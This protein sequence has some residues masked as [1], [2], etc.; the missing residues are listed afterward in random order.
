MSLAES[1]KLAWSLPAL[2]ALDDETIGKAWRALGGHPQALIRLSEALGT[3]SSL[4]EAIRGVIA[5]CW[6]ESGAADRFW[7]IATDRATYAVLL[8]A[9]VYRV[10]FAPEALKFQLVARGE[11]GGD[12]QFLIEGAPRVVRSGL[13]CQHMDGELEAY[14]W[15]SPALFSQI[16]PRLQDLWPRLHNG[17]AEYWKS[18][19]IAAAGDD[20]YAIPADADIRY[21]VEADEHYLQAGEFGLAVGTA[22]LADKTLKRDAAWAEREN[23]LRRHLDLPDLNPSARASLL[24]ALGELALEVGDYDGAM[25]RFREALADLGNDAH[26]TQANQIRGSIGII[27]EQRG[28]YDKAATIFTKT[29]EIARGSGDRITEAYSVSHLATLAERQDDYDRAARLHVE[30]LQLTSALG[31]RAGMASALHQLGMIAQFQ[32]DL[33]MARQHYEAAA[34]LRAVIGDAIESANSTAQLGVLA[35]HQGKWEEARA[36]ITK[37]LEVFESSGD[38]PGAAICYEKLGVIAHAFREFDLADSHLHRALTMHR[39]LGQAPGARSVLQCQA[40][41]SAAQGD[42]AAA[43]DLYVQ[44][45]TGMPGDAGT[46]RELLRVAAVLA[47]YE[48]NVDYLERYGGAIIEGMARKDIHKHGSGPRYILDLPYAVALTGDFQRAEELHRDVVENLFRPFIPDPSDLANAI[49]EPAEQIE[50]CRRDLANARFEFQ[51]EQLERAIELAAEALRRGQLQDAGRFHRY[52][53]AFAELL[54]AHRPQRSDLR[55]DIAF[56]C[57]QLGDLAF[58]VG[59]LAEAEDWY[60]RAMRVRTDLLRTMPGDERLAR[61]IAVMYERLA[62]IAEQLERHHE[63]MEYFDKLSAIRLDLTNREPHRQDLAE[64]YAVN[65]TQLAQLDPNRATEARQR[66]RELLEGFENTT[67]LTERATAILRWAREK[68]S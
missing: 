6:R 32:G 16:D 58:S 22:I 12:H 42:F 56:C 15:L 11:P 60:S 31:D 23:I 4:D 47:D 36:R 55:I 39:M 35:M 7:E 68:P 34:D 28:D 5:A 54:A 43:A 64:E 20:P 41:L 37:A 51:A 18:R 62:M 50:G 63:A 30:S 27:H 25:A 9:S 33:D 66:A 67:K 59:R 38:Q 52:S 1:T 45:L 53:L 57:D 3:T 2:S 21:L 26:D 8:A 17:A 40:E 65:M 49:R 14:H 29:A 46:L 24:R 13:L 44:C 19:F 10:P 61:G 48:A